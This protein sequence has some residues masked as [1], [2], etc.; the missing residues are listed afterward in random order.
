MKQFV[1]AGD[2]GLSEL[3]GVGPF[4]DQTAD[5]SWVAGVRMIFGILLLCALDIGLWAEGS[6]LKV[7]SWNVLY[8]FNHQRSTKESGDWIRRQNPDV[9]AL[10]ELNGITERELG[11]LSRQWGHGFAVTHKESGFPLGLASREPI[12]VWERRVEGFHH[13]FLHAETFG[14]HFFVVHFWPGKFEEVDWILDKITPLRELGKA[15]VVLGDFNGCSRQDQD[16]LV[17]HATAR[18]IDYTFVDRVEAKGF[19]DLVAKHDPKAK[20]S[21]PSPL[22][23]PR[24]SK[25]WDELRTKR[26]RIDFIFADPV[27]AKRSRSGTILLSK[28]LDAFSDHY[29][30]VVELQRMD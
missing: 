2:S 13:G 4:D 29:P 6:N 30:V 9:I 26:Y 23:I 24:W 5:S 21:C 14:I 11:D 7:I 20:V 27:L 28:E 25:D 12:R 3:R 19:V 18:E 8:G 15:V 1:Y 10:Q 17:Q 16:F 22:T